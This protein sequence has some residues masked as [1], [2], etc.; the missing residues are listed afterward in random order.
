MGFLHKHANGVWFWGGA[1]VCISTLAMCGIAFRYL[2]AFLPVL[3]AALFLRGR[4]QRH[5]TDHQR[6]VSC[7]VSILWLCATVLLLIVTIYAALATIGIEWT[8]IV[9]ALAAAIWLAGFYVIDW[10]RVFG[11]RNTP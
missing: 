11:E 8:N 5:Q 6:R 9:P 7:V 4:P 1:L 10:K 2:A 3:G